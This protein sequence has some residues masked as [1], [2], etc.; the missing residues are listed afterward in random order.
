MA[1]FLYSAAVDLGSANNTIF[2][3]LGKAKFAKNA[4]GA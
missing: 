4:V 1:V 3:N 2:A